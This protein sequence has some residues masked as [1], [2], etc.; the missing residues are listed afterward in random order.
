MMNDYYLN[1]A[2][3][4]L[5]ASTKDRTD[6][7]AGVLFHCPEDG[8]VLL[9]KRS[10]NGREGGSWNLPGG[11][12]KE[13][14]KPRDGALREAEEELG[15]LPPLEISPGPVTQGSRFT[16]HIF[17]SPMSLKDKKDFTEKIDLDTYENT[18]FEWFP[19]ENIP[20]NLHSSICW[21]DS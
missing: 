16:Y 8:T 7:G 2:T 15:V 14:E 3:L 13:D 9:L 5:K 10:E 18:E 12:L 4:Y 21:E 17:L 19:I 20:S 11:A 6:M 1:L